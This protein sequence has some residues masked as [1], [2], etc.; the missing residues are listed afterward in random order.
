MFSTVISKMVGKR[1][2]ETYPNWRTVPP[3]YPPYIV[4]YDDMFWEFASIMEVLLNIQPL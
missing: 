2:I 3:A 1:R 4:L